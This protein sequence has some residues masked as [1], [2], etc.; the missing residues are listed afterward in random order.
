M[1]GKEG[2]SYLDQLLNNASTSS[3]E[4][5]VE[6]AKENARKRKQPL[7]RYVNFVLKEY[8]AQAED[9]RRKETGNHASAQ[10]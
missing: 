8:F 5:G 1:A 7:S 9:A 10:S 6:Q 3:Q 2:E 4:A